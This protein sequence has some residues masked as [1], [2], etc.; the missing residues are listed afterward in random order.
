MVYS[1]A[2]DTG[3]MRAQN[4]DAAFASDAPVGCLPSLFVVADG[5]GG[6]Q[7]G[8]YASRRAVETIRQVLE[9]HASGEPVQAMSEAITTANGTIYQ[10]A[11][12]DRSKAG[13]GTTMVAAVI[14]GDQLSVANVGDSRLYLFRDGL[15]RQIT[16]DHS[17]VEEM[18]RKGEMAKD[19]ARN[20]P[21][22]SMITRAVGAEPKVRIDFFDETVEKG[23]LVLMCTDG[24]T[25]MVE[26]DE[27]ARVLSGE[28]SV[29]AKVREL[30]DKANE[31][32]GADNIT[33][34]IIDPF[35]DEVRAC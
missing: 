32:G 8:D 14:G 29:E 15:L 26:D 17:V 4:Q 33:V 21:K 19:R 30:I 11:K 12:S 27:I 7:A 5:M 23:D 34:I 24:L 1:A 6:H 2:T 31:N 35:S 3:R 22:R 16:Q 9:E 25:G 20:H 28:G 13:M 18:V 10:E